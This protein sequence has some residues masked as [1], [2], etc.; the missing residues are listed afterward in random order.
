MPG[1][2]LVPLDGSPLANRALAYASMLGRARAC[3]VLLLRVLT[4]QPPRGEELV[5]APEA[6]AELERIA[7]RLRAA[8]LN[9]ACEI[10]TTLFGTP[11]EVV[12]DTAQ[13]EGAEIIVMS[14]HGRSGLGRWVYGSVAEGVLRLA[15][16]PVLLVPAISH[17]TWPAR[18]APRIL[19][20]LDG[21]DVADR[22]IEPTSQWAQALRAEVVVVRVLPRPTA[23]AAAYLYEDRSAEQTEAE[24][25]LQ[26]ATAPLRKAGLP[27]TLLTPTGE[28]AERIAEIAREQDVD[29]ISMATHGRSGV[30]RV[31]LGSVATETLQR[32]AVPTLLSGVLTP[33]V[34]PRSDHSKNAESSQ[35]R[36]MRLLVPLDLTDKADAVLP[37]VSGIAAACNAEVVLLNVFLPIVELG[38]VG[39]DSRDEGITYLMA[40]RRMYL[41]RK[42]EQLCGVNV[43]IR[44]EALRH[45]EDVDEGIVRVAGECKATMLMLATSHLATTT[46][47][48]LGSV[49]RGVLARA[50]CPVTIVT[51]EPRSVSAAVADDQS[52]TVGRS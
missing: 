39:T 51:Y 24:Q 25:S 36:P 46:G 40:E 22:A 19:L 34:A 48:V 16:V 8:G 32:A 28:P 42:A 1:C 41:E 4:P 26:T 30:S 23:E 27:V 50:T 47:V 35:I 6:R 29:I 3:R 45:G 10:S 17:R 44:V 15:Q 18:R 43:S 21:S 7:A 33:A 12:V 9:V 11:A 5:Q 31:V 38:G 49:A 52:Q 14:T 37:E 13:R 20:A 2:V